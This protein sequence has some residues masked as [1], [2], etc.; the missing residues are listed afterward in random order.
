M[1]SYSVKMFASFL[2][3]NYDAELPTPRKNWTWGENSI[4]HSNNILLMQPKKEVE[5]HE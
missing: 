2:L 4:P 1:F 5:E 3:K